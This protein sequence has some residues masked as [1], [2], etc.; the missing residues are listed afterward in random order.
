[1]KLII[2]AFIALFS[3]ATLSSNLFAKQKKMDA[4]VKL[5]VFS[6][7][8]EVVQEFNS[9]QKALIASRQ[10]PSNSKKS[11]VIGAGKY[12]LPE[13]IILGTK[14]AGLTIEGKQGKDV[15]LFGGKRITNWKKAENGR[16]VANLPEVKQGKLF[17]RTLLVNGRYAERAR[18]P[19]QGRL[20]HETTFNGV[21]MSTVAGGWKDKPTEAELTRLKFKK[22]DIDTDFDSKN[23]E[24]TIYHHWDE[25]LVGVK[26]VDFEN[27]ILTTSI[28]TGHPIGCFN[29]TEYIIWNTNRG[30]T[31]PG[32]W[33]V[34]KMKGQLVY[35][36]LP[37]EEMG[38]V[39]IVVPTLDNVIKIQNSSDIT[40]K[41]LAICSSNT[42]MM[43]GSFGAKLFDG[44]ISLTKSVNCKFQN[45]NITGATGW[46]LKLFGENITVENCHIHDVGAGGVYVVGSN[47]VVKNNYIHHVGRVYYSTIALYAG[48]TDPNVKDEWEFGK[49]KI[50]VLL[51]HNEIHDAPY[52]GIGIGGTD[53]VIEYNKV[54]KVMQEL[55]DGSGIYATF[56]KNLV[57]RGN[58]VGDLTV[59]KHGKVHSYYLDEWTNNS[60]VEKNISFGV[61]SPC[62]NHITNGNTVRNNVFISKEP[63]LIAS[64]KSKEL[65]FVNNVFISEKS[66][67]LSNFNGIVN[68]AGNLFDV[69]DGEVYESA[70]SNY[71][72][73]KS[74]KKLVLSNN[75]I[76]E[77][78]QLQIVGTALL[79]TN[80]SPFWK[81]GM[82]WIKEIK[83]GNVK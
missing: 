21:W 25:T 17:F 63:M 19:E 29:S 1:M 74:K 75:N 52:V 46:G 70:S 16:W 20:A 38:N 10:Y 13:S 78:S 65:A 36:P 11:L 27:Q 35:W 43:V 61:N 7:D 51:S 8:K 41:N 72:Y 28:R 68:F 2:I 14:D 55:A 77:N 66:I 26:S 83:I 62:F 58:Y 56:C 3:V 12:Y 5:E 79:P 60:I 32:K 42:A 18:Y 69:P 6:G 54:T 39:E 57:M 31:K 45:L 30:M 23:A 48:V 44:A 71:D 33:Y 76:V 82:D 34:D 15:T 4:N 81:M 80:D 40:I 73:Q 53:N 24:L 64:P 37:G 49:D 59:G 9:I 67:T 22:E 50:N 47:A